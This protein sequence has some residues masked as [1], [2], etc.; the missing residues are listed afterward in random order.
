MQDVLEECAKEQVAESHLDNVF[1]GVVLKFKSQEE[2]EKFY[3]EHK[4]DLFD[5][6][7]VICVYLKKKYLNYFN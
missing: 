7:I 2:A 4:N 1:K 3:E 6:R 5:E